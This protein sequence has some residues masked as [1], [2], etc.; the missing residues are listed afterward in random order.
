MDASRPLVSVIADTRRHFDPDVCFVLG[1]PGSGKGTQCERLVAQHKFVHLSAGDL[2]RAELARG[3]SQG[4]NIKMLME[5]GLLVPVEVTLNLLKGA[6]KASGGDRFLVDGFPRAMDQAA[7]FEEAVCHPS[8]VLFLDVPDDEMVKR[9]L[10]RGLTSGR[11]DDN[12]ETIKHR[13]K[14][15]HNQSLP[16]IDR[17]SA[18]GK[19]ASIDGTGSVAQVSAQTDDTFR[20]QF[21]VLASGPSSNTARFGA[22]L[23]ER[24][25]YVF[26]SVP[27]LIDAEIQLGTPRGRAFEQLVKVSRTVRSPVLSKVSTVVFV[28]MCRRMQW[29]QLRS[30]RC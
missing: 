5:K 21:V 3:S 29:V 2:L 1:G 17:Y 14:T 8:R 25:G 18:E 22:D 11:G 13:L 4:D 6:M 24:F 20:T 15:F 19:V 10:H 28:R 12:A 16:V 7:V 26:L 27:A 23:A 30:L 9:L